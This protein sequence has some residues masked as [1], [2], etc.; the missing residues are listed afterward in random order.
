METAPEP[1]TPWC[2]YYALIWLSYQQATGEDWIKAL[3]GHSHQP[4]PSC[5]W[6]KELPYVDVLDKQEDARLAVP[7][8]LEVKPVKAIECFCSKDTKKGTGMFMGI[9]D[10]DNYVMHPNKLGASDKL[11]EVTFHAPQQENSRTLRVSHRHLPANA[12]LGNFKD[13]WWVCGEKAYLLLPYAW[14]GCCYMARLKLPYEVLTTRKETAAEATPGSRKKRELA[15]F[16]NLESYH[17]RIS[18]AEKW[19][20]GLFPWYGVTFLADHIDNITYTLQG[21]ANETIKG[22]EYLSNTQRS[23][24]LTLLKHD[25]ALDYILAKQGGLC[26]A[27]NLTGDACYTLIPDNSDNITNVIDALKQIRDAFGASEGAGQS[28][29]SWLHDKLGPLGAVIIQILVAVVLSL[30]LMFCCS[31]IIIIDIRKSNDITLGWSCDAGR[32]SPDAFSI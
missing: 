31:T 1:L 28:A 7:D 9:A 11:F 29:N 2:Q 30:S 6:L 13:I 3:V 25:M 27:L 19:G 20:I 4:H 16:H 22:F 21:F 32:S 8:A 14:T 26:M 23:H 17:W 10:C 24:R 5:S 18:L 15:E 12:T